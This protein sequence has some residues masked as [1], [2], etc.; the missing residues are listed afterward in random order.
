[1][2]LK[3]G[4]LFII[5]LCPGFLT[6]Q[7]SNRVIIKTQLLTNAIAHNP[8]LGIEKILNDKFSLELEGIWMRRDKTSNSGEGVH[9]SF[10]NSNGLALTFSTKYYFDKKNTI[11]NGKYLSGF[12]RYNSTTIKNVD[13]AQSINGSY[14]R[15]IDLHMQGPELGFLLG[16]QFLFKNFTSD[17]NFGLGY[18]WQSYQET[19]KSGQTSNDFVNGRYKTGYRIVRPYLHVTIGYML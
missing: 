5:T 12:I 18:Y 1:M 16:R 11:P 15:T 19:L 2:F 8:T 17:I 7:H 10:Y 3:K 13:K 14:L 9:Q 6:A 4:S